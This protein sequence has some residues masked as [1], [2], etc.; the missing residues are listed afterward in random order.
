[1][2]SRG[3]ARRFRGA[4]AA[5]VVLG[6]L[7]LAGDVLAVRG[8]GPWRRPPV[9]RSTA[10]VI[11]AFRAA[12]IELAPD[13]RTARGTVFL[14][15]RT[16]RSGRVGLLV[17]VAGRGSQVGDVLA[18][19]PLP[20]STEAVRFVGAQVGNVY[21]RSADFTAAGDGDSAVLQAIEALRR[22]G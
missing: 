10:E 2:T 3:E 16:P 14:R 4:I 20:A 9:P 6:A 19:N 13:S 11:A 5:L 17:V 12:G 7:A 22:P 21:V 18:T 15:E 1:M 8:A